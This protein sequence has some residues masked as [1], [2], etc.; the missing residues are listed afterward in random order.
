LKYFGESK[1]MLEGAAVF[2]NPAFSGTSAW[3]NNFL[4]R[5]HHHVAVPEAP[6]PTPPPPA[7]GLTPPGPPP[8]A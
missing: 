5:D 7:A 6:T 2:A 8:H 1:Q 4:G 3:A